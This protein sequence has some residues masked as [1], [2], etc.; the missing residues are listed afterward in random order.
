MDYR[1]TVPGAGG[2]LQK[3]KT[4]DDDGVRSPPH[5]VGTGSAPE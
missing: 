4:R 5:R 3:T 2:S 1:K